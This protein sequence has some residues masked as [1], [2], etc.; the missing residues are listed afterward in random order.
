MKLNFEEGGYI[1][2]TKSQEQVMVV[3]QAQDATNTLKTI[4]NAC[5][6]TLQQFKDLCKDFYD[7]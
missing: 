3:I 4:T 5:E 7:S 6:M 1:E 2:I